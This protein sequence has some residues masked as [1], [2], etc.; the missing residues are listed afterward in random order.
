MG[1]L[2]Q[3]EGMSEVLCRKQ[4][5]ELKFSLLSSDTSS[6]ANVPPPP[7]GILGES[8]HGDTNKLKR[9]DPRKMAVRN[10]QTKWPD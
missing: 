7:N 10:F 5:D 4:G 2:G 9:N 8:L 3:A 6:Q 1:K